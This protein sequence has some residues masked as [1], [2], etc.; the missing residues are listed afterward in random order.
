LKVTFAYKNFNLK[1]KN[2]EIAEKIFSQVYLLKNE[3]MKK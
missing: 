2:K 3:F 1:I